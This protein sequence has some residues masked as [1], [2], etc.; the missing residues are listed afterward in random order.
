MKWHSKLN[1]TQNG[2]SIK[3][4]WGGLGGAAVGGFTSKVIFFCSKTLCMFLGSPK[5]IFVF[6]PNFR[7]NRYFK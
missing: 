3:I 2:M 4:E 6:T 1:V 5:T 7:Q